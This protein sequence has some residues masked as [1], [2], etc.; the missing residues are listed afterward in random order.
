MCESG[1]PDGVDVDIIPS[2]GLL[3]TAVFFNTKLLI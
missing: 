2:V 1:F 3:P